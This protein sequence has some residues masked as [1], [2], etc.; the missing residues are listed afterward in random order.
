MVSEL[1]GTIE[2]PCTIL[3]KEGFLLECHWVASQGGLSLGDR[4]KYNNLA[5][6]ALL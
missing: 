6:T 5:N 1:A 4:K 3:C 2:I